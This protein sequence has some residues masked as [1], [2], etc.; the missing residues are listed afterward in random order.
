MV[1][2]KK[3]YHAL[4]AYASAVGAKSR[5]FAP[6]LALFA[7]ALLAFVLMAAHPAMA[8]TTGSSAYGLGQNG[9]P[10]AADFTNATQGFSASISPMLTAILPYLIGILA[11]WKLPWLLKKL[12]SGFTH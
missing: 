10:A 7:L 1:K 4:A 12:V 8:Q 9:A 6:K 2:T 11:V 5:S 3:T